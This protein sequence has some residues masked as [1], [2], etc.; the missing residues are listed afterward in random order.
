MND[1]NGQNVAM[2][3]QSCLVGTHCM[4]PLSYQQKNFNKKSMPK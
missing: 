2:K 3:R 1:A 4:R